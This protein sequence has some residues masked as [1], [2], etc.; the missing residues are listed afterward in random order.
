MTQPLSL[1]PAR[2]RDLGLIQRSRH[3]DPPGFCGCLLGV[4]CAWPSLSVWG[5]SCPWKWRLSSTGLGVRASTSTF[6]SPQHESLPPCGCRCR[7]VCAGSQGQSIAASR[8]ALQKLADYSQDQLHNL[9]SP[10]QHE[11]AVFP[12]QKSGRVSR[13]GQGSSKP[14]GGRGGCVTAQGA[15]A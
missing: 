6:P 15:G 1:Q 13:Q 8:Y 4:V 9:Q 12:A 11:N 7:T 14:S 3:Q 2:A 10:M 5:W